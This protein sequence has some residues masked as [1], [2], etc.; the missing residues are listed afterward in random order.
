M[1]KLLFFI[2]IPVLFN[3]TSK[4]SGIIEN[5]GYEAKTT[6]IY[7]IKQIEF[8]DSTTRFTIL[9]EFVPYWWVNYERDD[10]ITDEK[11]GESFLPIGIESAMFD[12]LIWMPADGDSIVTLIY[13][14]I[15]DHVKSI[16][17]CESIFGISLDPKDAGKVPGENVSKSAQKWINSELN[18]T[19]KEALETFETEAFFCADKARIVGSIKGYDKRYAM[20]TGII[21]MNNQF[22]REDYPIVVEIH[23]DGRFEADLPMLHPIYS[24]IFI[25]HTGIPFYIEP[26]Q[27]LAIVLDWNEFLMADRYRNRCYKFEKIEYQGSLSNINQQLFDFKSNEFNFNEFMKKVETLSP[28]EYVLDEQKAFDDNML[29]LEKYSSENEISEKAKTLMHNK[30]LLKHGE[31]LFNFVSRRKYKA[32]DNKDNKILSLPIPVDYYNFLQ[33]FPINTKSLIVCSD[34]STFINRYE[35]AE[36]FNVRGLIKIKH[37]EPEISFYEYLVKYKIELAESDLK[38]FKAVFEKNRTPEEEKVIKNNQKEINSLFKKYKN[39][40]NVYSGKHNKQPSFAKRSIQEWSI[41]DSLL[42][43]SLK[44][45]NNLVHE[46]SKVRSLGFIFE[47][48]PKEECEE[49]WIALKQTITEPFI[50]KTGDEMFAESFSEDGQLAYEL[51]L[52]EKGTAVF[53]EIVDPFRGKI[54]FIDFWATSCGPCVG[55]I[56]RMKENREKYKDNSDFDFI[57]ITDEGGSPQKRYAAFVEEQELKNTYR[58]SKDD[59]NYL[60]QLFKFNGIPRYVVIDKEGKVLNDDF[61]MQQFDQELDKILAKE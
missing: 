14:R 25:N 51:P 19:N 45:E 56:K 55:G 16:Q 2:I 23:P 27:T 48:S 24:N 61:S 41:K 12:S 8:T 33:D 47:N 10:S 6:G 21:Y 54:L 31:T 35:Y 26:G 59:Y 53:K 60:R 3:C 32:R 52:D 40:L 30:L 15:P 4:H 17:W 1:K 50:I 13:P 37:S 49:L 57:F 34:F 20:E 44:L 7:T 18:N 42:V 22:T 9:S 46:I 11:T 29:L 36:P 38:I 28:E 43:H 5:P 39:E 58:L